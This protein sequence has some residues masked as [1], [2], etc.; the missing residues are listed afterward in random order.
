[1]SINAAK[2][3]SV[4]EG[5]NYLLLSLQTT[6]DRRMWAFMG[7]WGQLNAMQVSWYMEW[8]KIIEIDRDR[9]F[10]DLEGLD[11]V[12][13]QSPP[14]MGEYLDQ[15]KA[16]RVDQTF[17]FGRAPGGN[18]LHFLD[19]PDVSST[20]WWP[21]LHAILESLAKQRRVDW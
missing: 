12:L 21:S 14:L 18:F 5:F 3:I 13:L 6:A 9:I 11:E 1:M 2:N 19:G 17:K 15:A 8:K 20:I 4:G 10:Y 7:W 16:L